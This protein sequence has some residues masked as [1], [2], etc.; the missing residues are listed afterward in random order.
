MLVGLGTPQYLVSQSDETSYLFITTDT[1]PLIV[2][3]T[4]LSSLKLM[5]Y[6]SIL[7][8]FK[9]SFS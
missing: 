2:K 1:K 4:I 6:V 3:V 8:V 5:L 9:Y 7:A